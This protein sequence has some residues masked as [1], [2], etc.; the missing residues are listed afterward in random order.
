MKICFL[1]DGNHPN[2]LN[3]AAYFSI[4]LGHEVHVISL[5]RPSLLEKGIIFHYLQLPLKGK[6]RYLSPVTSLRRILRSISPDLL[7]GYR[8]TSYAFLAAK[9][10]F[11]PLVVVAQSQKAA[12][13]FR[14]LR[15]PIQLLAARYAVR[16][17]D[18]SI[19]WGPHM[20]EDIVTLGGKKETIFTQPRGVDLSLFKYTPK[21]PSRDLCIVTTRG[22]KPEYNLQ[23]VI[24]AVAQLSDKIDGIRYMVIGDG[25]ARERLQKLSIDLNIGDRVFFKGNVPYDTIPQYLSESDLYISPVPEDGVSSS[26]L[27]A[28]AVGSYPIV[29]NIKANHYWEKLGCGFMCFSPKSADELANKILTF[30]QN[31]ESY[32]K[33]LTINRSIVEKKASWSHNMKII[34]R[35]LLDLV[36]NAGIP[37]NSKKKIVSSSF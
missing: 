18:L 22:L 30:H 26:L 8:L 25:K 20:A 17:A 12:G 27:E 3:W 24:G 5:N 6:F 16:N 34:E 28:M 21:K 4:A 33:Q 13:D 11:H 29:T 9:S 10:K 35:T 19:A 36:H 23:T 14:I 31:R 2:T 15:K 7:I 37:M 32:R 1:A